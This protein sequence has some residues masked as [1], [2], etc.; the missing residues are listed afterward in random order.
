MRN[1]DP[2]EHVQ[3][4]V[5]GPLEVNRGTQPIPITA[6][7]HQIVLAMLLLEV[8]RTVS[9][10]RLVDAVWA[11]EPPSTARSQIQICVSMLRKLLSGP[12]ADILSR[13]P[14]YMLRITDRSLDLWRFRQLTVA[15]EDIAGTHPEE[16][17]ARYREG[18]ALWRGEACAGVASQIVAQAVIRL[19]EERW[20]TL[21]ACLDLELRLGRHHRV[22]GELA[23]LVAAEPLRERPRA[24]LMVALY[25]SGRQAEALEVYRAGRE[26]LAE[27]LGTDPGK[28]LRALE[29]AILSGDGALEASAGSVAGWTQETAPVVPQPRQL[30]AVVADFVGRN[31]LM[32]QACEILMP[33]APTGGLAG[34][35]PVVMLTGRGGIGKTTLAIQVAHTVQDAFADG[36]LYARLRE[37]GG[38]ASSPAGVLEQFL[39]SLGVSGPVIPDSLLERTAMLRS[40]LAGRRV[41]I[42]LD[43]AVSL[44]QVEPLLPGE[45]GCGVIITS[46]AR[47]PG[48]PGVVQFEVGVLDQQAAAELLDQVI[49]AE[50]ASA[51]AEATA[52]LIRLCEGLPLALRISASKLAARGHWQVARMVE[53]LA[54]ERRRLDEL[55]L[56]GASIRATLELSYHS[57]SKEAQ[58]LLDRLSLLDQVDF[59]EWVSAPLLDMSAASAEDV[60]DEL[61]SSGLVEARATHDRTVRYRMHDM[62][63][64]FARE[65]LAGTHRSADRLAAIRR[66]I[67]CWLALVGEAHRRHHGGDFYLVR[68]DGE[69]WPLPENLT[70]RLLASPMQWFHQERNGLVE[71]ILLSSRARLDELC[72]DLAVESVTFFEL[73]LYPDDWYQTHEA[74]LA[75]TRGAGNNRGT[76]A[77]LYSLGMRSMNRGI[78]ESRRYLRQSLELWDQLDD[79]HGRAL[80]LAG[81]AN[82]DRLIGDFD[83][84][85]VN[86]DLALSCFEEVGDLAGL[87]SVLRGQGQIAME[88]DHPEAA[89]ELLERSIAVSSAAGAER[90]VTQSLYYSAEFLWRSGDFARAEDRLHQVHGKTHGTGDIV[91]E[92]YSLLGLA[93]TRTRMGTLSQAESDLLHAQTLAERSGDVL[94]QGRIML[95]KADLD[96]TSGRTTRARASLAEAVEAFS[97]LGSPPLWQARCQDL[98]NRIGS[99]ST[100]IPD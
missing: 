51:E 66:Y 15:A 34:H 18:L 16:A 63:R 88:R 61:V 82:A 73:G 25:R 80:A 52:E 6:G 69:R 58:N 95:A 98:E 3:F 84:A 74:A 4:R 33:A 43:D 100:R 50:R 76:A 31:D 94:L 29:Q 28:E 20:A 78:E 22:A 97:R 14:G 9:V 35:L 81:L 26:L 44:S 42:V 68:G 91:G 23:E 11:E 37:S 45:P 79:T 5:L 77:L 87:A 83:A 30:P 64:L 12:G 24:L 13:P 27:E 57:L 10:E 86:Y 59:P 39:R 85:Q 54:D 90:D 41:L 55:D 56:E 17:V 7:R 71:A 70:D 19:N 32:Q 67:G 47:L 60:L 99:L 72:W 92:G 48:P 89:H 21:E 38:P 49:G 8:G 1:S 46:R 75:V 40:C 93:I 65:K 2:D 62:V 53:R 96:A 36:Q